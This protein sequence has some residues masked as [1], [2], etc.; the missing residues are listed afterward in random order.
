MNIKIDREL[1]INPLGNVAGIVE[2]R[3]A[4]PILSNLLLENQENNLKFTATDL[5][6]QI[7]TH[8]KTKL[9]DN[10]YKEIMELLLKI[11]KSY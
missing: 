5:E 11:K 2:K 9:S 10:E 7:S 3:H 4:L 8:I 6:M 1:L